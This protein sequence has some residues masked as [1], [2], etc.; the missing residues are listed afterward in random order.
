M[1]HE[2]YENWIL[3][4]TELTIEEKAA[5]HNHLQECSQCWK[6]GNNWRNIRSQFSIVSMSAPAD[7]FSQRWKASADARRELKMRNQLIRLFLLMGGMAF[8]SILT[9]AIQF[10]IVGS[11]IDC[12]AIIPTIS[13]GWTTAF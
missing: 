10:V 6:L 12:A 1:I 13:P 5:L 8:V 9:L 11:P 7:G 2:P 3:S 4:E